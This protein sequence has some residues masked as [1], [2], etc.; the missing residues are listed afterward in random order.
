MDRC[1]IIDVWNVATFDRELRG[2]LDAHADTICDFMAMARRIWLEREV[3]DRTQPYA[4]N[5]FSDPFTWLSDHIGILMEERTIRAWH[6]CRMT[7]DEVEALHREGIQLST[8]D[9]LKARLANQVAR[10]AFDQ[11]VSDQ[12]LAGSPLHSEQ[13]GLRS[14]KFWMVSHPYEVGDGGVELLLESWGGEV[15]YFWQRDPQLQELLRRIGRPRVLEIAAPMSRVF[16][17]SFAGSAVVAAYARSLG[18]QCDNK[19]FDLYAHQPLGPSAILAVHSEGEKSF[20]DMGKGY[21]A[22]FTTEQA[23]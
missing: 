10:S 5:A 11:E 8:L 3:S 2:D 20:A 12:L 15:V 6:Y 9:T 22:E 23:G 16:S 1:A 14:N 19:M 18:C 21:P 17:S 4:E 7:D 13:F